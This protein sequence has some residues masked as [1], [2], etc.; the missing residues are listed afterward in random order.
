LSIV[1]LTWLPGSVGSSIG[2]PFLDTW[3]VFSGYTGLSWVLPATLLG[4]A[5]ASDWRDRGLPLHRLA[6]AVVGVSAAIAFLITA[7][8]LV[9]A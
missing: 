6:G 2:L 7:A 3:G 9:G 1:V 5:A 4:L 8:Q